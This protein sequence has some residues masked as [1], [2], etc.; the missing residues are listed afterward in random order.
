MSSIRAG[1]SE[2]A[3]STFSISL[4][5]AV[6]LNLKHTTCRIKEDSGF[7][8]RSDSM[9]SVNKDMIN[10]SRKTIFEGRMRST[11]SKVEGFTTCFA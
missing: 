1:S 7:D 9:P 4:G 10:E 2:N 3:R 8:E 5:E 6:F 11:I